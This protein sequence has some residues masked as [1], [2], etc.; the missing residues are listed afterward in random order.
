MV[1]PSWDAFTGPQSSIADNEEREVKQEIP[2]G[3][4]DQ[5]TPEGEKPEWGNFKDVNTYQGEEPEKD[6]GILEYF[7][8]NKTAND[9]R[10]LEQLAGAPGNLEKFGKETLTNFPTIGGVVGWGLSKLLGPEKWERLVKGQPGEQQT[11]PTSQD[12]KKSSQDLSK[13][14]TKAKTP[15]E[16]KLQE[17]TEDVGATLFSRRVPNAVNNFLIPAAA[18]AAKEIVKAT[19]FGDDKANIV[20]AA[21]W[22]PLTLAGNVNANYYASNLMN[23][24]RNGVPATLHAD[25]PRLLARLDRVANSTLLLHSDPRSALARDTLAGI[26]RDIANGQTSSQALFTQ[27]DAINAAKR[28]RDMFSLTRNDQGFA[29]RAIDEVRNAVRDEI[30]EVGRAHPQALQAWQ[31]GVRAWSV[32]HQSNAITNFVRNLA[33]GPYAKAIT[34]PA[35]ALF[36]GATS[37]GAVKSPILALPAAAA[38]SAAYK[39]GQTLYRVYQD[40]NL[41]NYYWNAISAAQANN[42]PA[43]ISNYQKLNEKLESTEKGSKANK[44]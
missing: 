4:Q 36:L 42:A 41:R 17:F 9:S 19:G 7:A 37:L 18:N 27:Y 31:D 25:V 43:F 30:M 16:E 32:I 20:K 13:G 22:L 35:S 26:R 6:E 44:K 8:R 1:S 29:R 14:Y 10:V 11:L 15:G 38:G 5:K 3:V 24:G 34:G 12:F 33:N 28:N 21:V 23:Q 2:G 40:P 39:T